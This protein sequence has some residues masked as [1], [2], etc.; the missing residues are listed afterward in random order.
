MV[1]EAIEFDHLEK[2]AII[3]GVVLIVVAEGA[4]AKAGAAVF[5]ASSLLLFG[6]SALYHRVKWGVRVHAVLRRID[7]ANIYLLIAG[8]YTPMTLLCLPRD[9]AIFLLTVIWI[10]AGLGFRVF[11][12]N[13]PRWLYVA[14]YLVLG[15]GALLFIA[16]FF[17]ANW[18]AMTLI[19]MGGV[20]YTLGAAVYGTKR[21]NPFPSAFGFHEIFHAFTVLAFISQW[22][23]ILLVAI[24]PPLT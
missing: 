18:I 17:R 9:K 8:T 10:G 3:L 5:F 16:D 20:F 1:D 2:L 7:H 12:L 4:A 6:T 22:A 19:L 15:W 14:L 24:N 11:W 13:A 23:G 21:P